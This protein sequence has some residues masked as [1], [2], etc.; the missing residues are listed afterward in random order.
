M[1]GN[2]RGVVIFKGEMG[3]YGIKIDHHGVKTAKSILQRIAPFK[4]DF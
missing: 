3:C 4:L 1:W 2:Y